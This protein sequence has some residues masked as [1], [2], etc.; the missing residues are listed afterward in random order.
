MFASRKDSLFPLIE[1][2]LSEEALSNT[3][4][5]LATQEEQWPDLGGLS[6]KS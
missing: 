6:V 4:I 2:L 1:E 5:T 3:G